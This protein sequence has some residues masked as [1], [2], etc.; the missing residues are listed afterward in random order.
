MSSRR[1]NVQ[2]LP[3]ALCAGLTLSMAT[4]AFAA[5]QPHPFVLTAY[6]TAIGGH[7]L[8]AGR[9]PVALQQLRGHTSAAAFDAA[10][11]STNRCVALSMTAQWHAAQAACDT[12]VRA[13]SR[14]RLDSPAWTVGSGV[15]GD[16]RLAAA[17]T[18]RG[19]MRWLSHDH[20]GAQQDFARARTLAPDSGFVT[21]NLTAL[22][23][24]GTEVHPRG[25]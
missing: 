16:R 2:A 10:A 23:F 11:V 5:E 21:R 20:A 25:S 3:L 9:Y 6:P 8:L 19:V 15:D 18:D 12:A 22:K 4:A 17:Y 13:A 7:A 24:H 14:A 1:R